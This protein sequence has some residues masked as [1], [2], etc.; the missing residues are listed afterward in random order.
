MVT[1]AARRHALAEQPQLDRLERGDPLVAVERR[2]GPPGTARRPRRSSSTRVERRRPG[3]P[4]APSALMSPKSTIPLMR[5]A[6]STRALSVVRSVWTACARSPGHAGHHDGLEAVEHALHERALR[7]RR[8]SPARARRVRAGVLDVPEHRP[9]QRAGRQNPRSARPSRAVVSPQ[10]TSA[11]SD[12]SRGSLRL[13]AGQEVVARARGGS[14][15]RRSTGARPRR[16]AVV[17]RAE[18][19]PRAPPAAGPGPPAG[20]AGRPRPPCRGSPGPRPRSRACRSRA[21]RRRA[22]SSRNVWSR[23]LPRSRAPTAATPNVAGGD[24]GRPRRAANVG[25]GV[26]RTASNP[27]PVDVGAR[28][29]AIAGRW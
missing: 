24:G 29:S 23:S 20:R 25:R 28:S 12:R 11:A 3:R 1:A 16:R 14:R 21:R 19:A 26:A 2:A 10:A 15:R 5:P 7:R 27:A 9:Q 18:H 4:A 8:G 17:G 22:S 13:A 6:S